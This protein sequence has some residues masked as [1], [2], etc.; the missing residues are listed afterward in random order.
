MI[1][2]VLRWG[3]G[4]GGE[5]VGV[6]RKGLL[7]GVYMC[8]A[9]SDICKERYCKFRRFPH[10]PPLAPPRKKNEVSGGGAG[11]EDVQY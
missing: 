11:G 9:Y 5:C 10:P 8:A 2:G 1:F 7:G 3:G 6:W 4:G